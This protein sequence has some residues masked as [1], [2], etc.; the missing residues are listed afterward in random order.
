[1][2]KL[3]VSLLTFSHYLQL[4]QSVPWYTVE[5]GFL[6]ETPLPTED[7]FLQYSSSTFQN[8]LQLTVYLVNDSVYNVFLTKFKNDHNI[9]YLAL[10]TSTNTHVTDKSFDY[11][12]LN[13]V[14]KHPEIF[15]ATLPFF[16]TFYE[17]TSFHIH[18]LLTNK[19]YNLLQQKLLQHYQLLLSSS[20][21][22]LHSQKIAHFDNDIFISYTHSYELYVKVITHLF[23]P[24]VL[25]LSYEYDRYQSLD[26]MLLIC[27][28]NRSFCIQPS[29]NI[30]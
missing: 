11:F 18:V 26:D 29:V 21:L 6:T 1:M 19:N 8:C 7:L 5:L 27:C 24:F 14:Q 16:F 10:D 12:F 28:T 9:N 17:F 22:N 30:L 4:S 20:F 15:V 13:Y 3:T 23:K 2:E 25:T